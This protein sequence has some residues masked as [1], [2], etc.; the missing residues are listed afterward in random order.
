MN[1]DISNSMY[2]GAY[3]SPT[4]TTSPKVDSTGIFSITA[5][6]LAEKELEPVRYL[7]DEMI[8]S[9]LSIIAGEAKIGKSLL[10]TGIADAVANGTTFLTRKV[11]QGEVFYL[12][13][14]DTLYRL[15]SRLN[16]MGVMPSPYLHLATTCARLGEG[17]AEQ[18]RDFKSVHPGL[19]LVIFD[20]L[21]WIRRIERRQS[22][23]NDVAELGELKSLATELG[24]SILCVHHTVKSK[25][26]K[27]M[28]KVSGTMGI[29]GTADT[30]LVMDRNDKEY[31]LS[32]IGKDVGADQIGLCFDPKNLTFSLAGAQPKEVKLPEVLERLCCIIATCGGFFGTNEEF[33]V[34]LNDNI[35][36]VDVVQLKRIAR[37]FVCELSLR[38]VTIVS[39]RK[40]TERY[41]RITYTDHN[42][43]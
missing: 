37:D 25:E 22:Y 28:G 36:D 31:S 18:I 16:K 9:G 21:Q 24:I 34:W 15:Q 32:Y 12:S 8:G 11:S 13:L 1:K 19:C 38:G 4:N 23:A 20:T 33:S 42:F 30:V 5:K 40:A 14:E 35:G 17:L 43:I 7:V 27:G 39:E 2:A 6:E 10:V 29:V 41:T 3:I 26:A